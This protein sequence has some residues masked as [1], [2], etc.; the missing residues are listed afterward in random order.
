MGFVESTGPLSEV[1]EGLMDNTTVERRTGLRRNL[2]IP[3]RLRAKTPGVEGPGE[4]IDVSER[5]VQFRTSVPLRVG[6][7]L[8]LYLLLPDRIAGQRV[9]EWH[10]RGRV[11]R[12]VRDTE[13]T[14]RRTVA[15]YF[16]EV[17]LFREA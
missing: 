7:A 9:S 4:S 2:A 6:E 17:C 13:T 10:C 14:G 12:I 11:V 15:V 8:D 5:G 1:S 16:E 3:L